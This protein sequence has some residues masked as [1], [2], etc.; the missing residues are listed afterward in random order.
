MRPEDDQLTPGYLE[1][2]HLD[3]EF[4]DFTA[5]GRQLI[6]QG[7]SIITPAVKVVGPLDR[8][9]LTPFRSPVPLN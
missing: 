4:R 6:L 8:I 9:A 7:L 5:Q 3:S 2:I 1:E